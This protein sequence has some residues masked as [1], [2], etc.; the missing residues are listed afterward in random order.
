MAFLESQ[1]EKDG[2]IEAKVYKVQ[3]P[4]TK[5]GPLIFFV[6]EGVIDDII[7]TGNIKTKDY[8]SKICIDAN[9][10]TMIFL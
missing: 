7:I 3:R 2:Y 5:P 10:N 6:A 8:F 4:K 1:L 9:G